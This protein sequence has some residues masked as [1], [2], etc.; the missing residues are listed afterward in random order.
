MILVLR[1]LHILSGA[2]WYGSIMFNARFLLPSLGAVGPGAGAVVGQLNQRG[3][4]QALMGA[5]I[6]NVAS[7]VWLMFLVSGGAM[8][9]WMRS[10]MGRTLAAGGTFAILDRLL[11][12][13]HVLDI[14]GRSYGLRDLEQA[15][16]RPAPS[17]RRTLNASGPPLPA[18]ASGLA[19]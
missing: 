19:L 3:L 8:G 14:R 9:D 11:H 10:P 5:G 1:L 15:V 7:G 6:V 17:P 12:N 4:P 16:T 18:A 2:F 13:S